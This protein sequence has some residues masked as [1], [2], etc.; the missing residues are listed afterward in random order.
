[1]PS[2]GRHSRH[3]G[4][5]LPLL[6]PQQ[7]LDT[8]SDDYGLLSLGRSTVSDDLRP[9]GAA[10][11]WTSPPPPPGPRDSHWSAA[12]RLR[13]EHLAN[14]GRS[15]PASSG[16]NDQATAGSGP[17]RPSDERDSEPLLVSVAWER[18]GCL[19]L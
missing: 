2:E 9:A 10:G 1:M 15:D 12:G 7:G 13:Q 16:L 19:L 11:G 17:T 8:I 5:H 6:S 4:A 14:E 3:S 18:A